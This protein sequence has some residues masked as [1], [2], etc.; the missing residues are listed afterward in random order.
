MKE[1]TKKQ[2]GM[3]LIEILVVLA[4]LGTIMTVI[5]GRVFGN[6]DKAKVST[7]KIQIAKVVDAI[8]LF[9]NDCDQLPENLDQLVNA[10]S[11]DVCETWGPKSYIKAKELR[12]PWKNDFVYEISGGEF[13]V[14]SLGK[15]GAPGGEG[16]ATDITSED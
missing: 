7:A 4:I 6:K 13:T 10:P 8:T 2:S 1:T 5:G 12:D 11:S 16:L 15:D 9:Y 14:T 3:S